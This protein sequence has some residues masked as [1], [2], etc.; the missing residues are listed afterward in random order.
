MNVF[1]RF[2]IG[3]T[4]SIEWCFDNKHF[5]ERLMENGISRQFI[6][7]CVMYEEPISYEYLDSNKYAVIF[8]APQSKDYNEI[9]IVFACNK[10]RIDLVTI[11]RN[12]ET[13]TNRQNKQ[14]QS[15]KKKCVE[16][17]KLKA[18]SKRKF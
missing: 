2:I 4:G 17:K 11:M 5:N 10:N 6:V 8:K 16:K 15:N 13:T 14:F 1:D 12:N 3:D 18:I 9:R 7:D